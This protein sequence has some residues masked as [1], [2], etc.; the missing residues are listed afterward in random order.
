MKTELTTK[1]K[2]LT[3]YI[4]KVVKAKTREEIRQLQ[5]DFNKEN[6]HQDETRS[7]IDGNK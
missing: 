7:P 5:A 6:N 1:L 3:E 2:A 4:D